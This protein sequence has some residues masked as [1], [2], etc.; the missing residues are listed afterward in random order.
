MKKINENCNK[1]KVKRITEA[2]YAA[3]INSLKEKSGE[4]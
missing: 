4:S 1:K 2:E 3:Y